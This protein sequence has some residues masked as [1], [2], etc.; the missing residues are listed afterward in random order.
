[1]EAARSMGRNETAGDLNFGEFISN[2]LIWTW[3]TIEAARK[4]VKSK[5]RLAVDIFI[6]WRRCRG[7]G[8]F[9]GWIRREFVYQFRVAVPKSWSRQRTLRAEAEAK[10][11]TDLPTFITCI[12][13]YKLQFQY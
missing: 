5:S 13:T 10:I 12:G 7:G 1:M 2:S 8:I 3:I 4:V 11:F 9:A 6:S